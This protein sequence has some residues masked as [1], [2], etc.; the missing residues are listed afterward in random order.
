MYELLHNHSKNTRHVH[1]LPCVGPYRNTCNNSGPFLNIFSTVKVFS[2]RFFQSS[3]FDQHVLLSIYNTPKSKFDHLF[4]P[5]ESLAI[6]LIFPPHRTCLHFFN[7]HQI[8]SSSF[9]LL[10]SPKS[11]YQFL[12]TNLIHKVL[13]QFSLNN[14]DY[15]LS[16]KL[17]H[18][19][20]Q[21]NVFILQF[22]FV[23]PIFLKEGRFVY[24]SNPLVWH[25]I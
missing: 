2:S 3:H 6:Q 23:D 17:S 12:Y 10:A 11:P 14:I 25:V 9:H 24:L 22:V 19:L 15:L 5:P 20:P 21:L 1:P 4:C 13:E 16:H 18:Q 7:M 8:S